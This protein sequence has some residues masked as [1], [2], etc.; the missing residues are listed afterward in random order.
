MELFT[1]KPHE[2]PGFSLKNK[3]SRHTVKKT[4]ESRKQINR[5]RWNLLSLLV[6]SCLKIYD[7]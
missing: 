6:F 7:R 2:H 4:Q 1:N 3:D 5:K